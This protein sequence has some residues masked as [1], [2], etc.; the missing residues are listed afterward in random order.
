MKKVLP[1]LVSLIIAPSAFAENL[2]QVY[3]QTRQTNPD[4]KSALA[5]KEKAYAAISGERASL[6]P[7]LG[8][9]ASYS[10]SHGYRENDDVNG[11]SGNLGLSLSQS[12]FNYSYWKNL[13]ISKQQ[14]SITDIAY[15][16]Q[17]QT[18]ILTAS[19]Y[20]FNVLKALDA[21]SFIEAQKKSIYRQLE[22]VRQQHKVGLVAITDVQNA[23]ANYDLT[24]ANEVSAINDLNNALEN[25]RQ[26][27]GRFY[28]NLASIDT[29]LFKTE[30]PVAVNKLL[31][32]SENLNLDLLTAR[33]SRDVAKEQ[34]RLAEAGHMPTLTLNASTGLSKSQSYGDNTNNSNRI[35]GANTIGIS[36]DL[37]IF[38]GGATMSKVEQ[39]QYNYVSFSEQLEKANRQVINSVRSSYNNITSAISSIKAYE[40]SVVSAQSSLDA[41]E[42]GYEVGTRT[43]VDVLSA[44]TT[45][46]NTKKQLSDAKYD[47]LISVLTLKNAIGTLDAN[48]LVQLNKMLGKDTSVLANIKN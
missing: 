25:L 26:V 4:L 46:Y 37:P 18:L 14:A 2:I 48:D 7:Q 6:L 20:Y 23:Q 32:Q 15:Q 47:Y 38:S 16:S 13:D 30:K 9:S 3:E 42:S 36:F 24:I 39:A 44:T 5:N 22:Q 17:E 40:Q 28:S 21:L 43:I 29:Q 10:L 31:Q 33:L 11:K 19:T 34:I 12:L 45:L 8:L 35:T 27:S 1:L 41:T